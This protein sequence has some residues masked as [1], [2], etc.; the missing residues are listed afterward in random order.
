MWNMYD[1]VDVENIPRHAQAVAG[2]VG[3]EWPTYNKLRALFPNAHVLSIAVNA[4]QNA[5]CLDV[6]KGDATIEEAPHWIHRQHERGLKLPVIYI[7]L[8]RYHSLV[9]EL[10]GNNVKVAD[11]RLW[12]AHYTGH[13]H[14]CTRHTCGL[15][16]P[17]LG[18]STLYGTQWTNRA[19]GKN[20]DESLMH[21]SFFPPL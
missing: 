6:E 19:D 12:I 1:S 21:S 8:S 18:A 2:Y 13:P 10:H 14:V 17:L 15:A 7:E 20:L 3:G 4:S 16:A 9:D 11:I 5:H